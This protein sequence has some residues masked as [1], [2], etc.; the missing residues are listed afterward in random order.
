MN[1]VKY[2]LAIAFLILLSSCRNDFSFEPSQGNLKFS[3]QTVCLDTV[4]T[5]IGSSTYRLKVYNQS[6]NDIS[7]PSINLQKGTSSKFRLMVDGV[8]GDGKSFKNVELLANDSLYIFIETTVDIASA[9]PADF[10]YTD[11]IEFHNTVSAP[12]TVDLVTLVQDAFF[13]FPQRSGPTGNYLYETINLGLNQ[14]NVPIQYIGSNLSRTDP[15]NGD[16]LHLTNQKPY[17]IYGYAFVPNNENLVIDKGARVFFHANSGIIIPR[18][19]SFQINGTDPPSTDLQ[20]LANEVVFEGDRLEPMFSDVV[21]QWGAIVNYSDSN[22]NTINHL[23]IKNATVGILTEQ[24]LLTDIYVP[25]LTI[26]NS[27]IYN[28]SNIGIL[29]RGA[30][31]N[32]RN[33][34]INN[35]GEASLAATYGGTY[36]FVHCTF[37]NN[38]NSSKQL[39]VFVSNFLETATTIFVNNLNQADFTN[40]IIYGS[41][42]VEMGL[43]KKESAT[44]N[45]KFTNCLL[46]FNNISNSLATNPE[47]QFDTTPARYQNV[48]IAQNSTNL[49]PKFVNAA[50]NKLWLSAAWNVAAMPVAPGFIF[51]DIVGKPRTG[52]IALGAYQFV[53]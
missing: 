26:N 51:N 9:N 12:Q 24:R 8:A 39:A 30:Q 17:V 15:T 1:T 6:D 4:F 52:A 50:K 18:S 53:P 35:C 36:N 2:F 22:L 11:K 14:N 48:F 5:N 41:N 27:Q 28:C 31:I 3:K 32:G 37:N 38:F 40:C 10:L 45:P 47:Y 49:N 21:G 25:K 19:A 46:K 23:T 29:A 33:V 20:S 7:I 44:F 43:A 42:A 34:V 16:E 13:I